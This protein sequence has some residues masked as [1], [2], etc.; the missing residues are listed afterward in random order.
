MPK[1]ISHVISTQGP[2]AY[3][4]DMEPRADMPC[5]V[6][7]DMYFSFY[8]IFGGCAE[9]AQRDIGD[10]TITYICT[11]CKKCISISAREQKMHINDIT[12]NEKVCHDKQVYSQIHVLPKFVFIYQ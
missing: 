5:D 1:C 8:H 11:P 10:V 2:K 3:R 12:Y 7:F 9:F 4:A 6:G